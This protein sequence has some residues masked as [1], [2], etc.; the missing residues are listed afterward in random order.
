VFYVDPKYTSKLCPTHNAEITYNGSR[1]GKCSKGNELWHRDVV[2]CWNLFFKAL[3]G[4]GSIAPSPLGLL[5]VDGSPMPLGST[6]THDPTVVKKPLWA[7]WKSLD[8]TNKNKSIS[9]SI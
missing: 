7:R 1:I 5:P 8:A 9:T 2:A 3:G 4:D 6:A